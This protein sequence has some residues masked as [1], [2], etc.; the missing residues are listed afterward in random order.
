[1]AFLDTTDISAG[2]DFRKTILARIRECQELAVLLT[3]SSIDRAWVPA[4]IGAAIG[5]GK[6]VIGIVYAVE[7]EQLHDRGF[8]SLI[9]D[10]ALI[11]LD[12]LD[13]YVAAV[14]SRSA[15]PPI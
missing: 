3:P 14:R 8:V 15:H 7:M 13:S 10:V 9:G 5:S 4:E 11:P 12:D 1:L 2:D 6:R